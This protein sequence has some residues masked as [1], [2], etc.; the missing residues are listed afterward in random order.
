MFKCGLCIRA[1]NLNWNNFEN[2]IKNCTFQVF[3][4]TCYLGLGH[5]LKVPV[6][7]TLSFLEPAWIAN[8]IGNPLCT[9][10]FPSSI[11]DI[12]KITTFS[13]R[14]KNALYKF[15]SIIIFNFLT[16]NPQTEAMRK[17]V[18]PEMPSIREV[19]KNIAL[20]LTNTHHSF[21]GVRPTTPAHIE[22]GGLHISENEAQ[23]TAVGLKILK[24][25]Y[26]DLN[27]APESLQNKRLCLNLAF[28][29]WREI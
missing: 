21:F 8:S 6:I 20:L 16:E 17:Y 5:F 3:G 23:F 25:K 7:G 9:S 26:W 13:N 14:L 10:F 18:S 1:R 29:F 11:M 4:A 12:E 15:L 27:F 19:E 2:E 24:T 28:S 22:V